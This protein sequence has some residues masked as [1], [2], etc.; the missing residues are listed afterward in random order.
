LINHGAAAFKRPAGQC[1]LDFMKTIPND[2][3]IRVPG[4]LNREGLL[5]C[6]PETLAEVLVHK[7]YDYEKPAEVRDFLV[8][9]LGAGLILTEGE[10]HKFQRKHITP[11]FSFRHIKELIPVFWSRSTAMRDGILA[12]MAE[13]PESDGRKV[14]EI[15]DWATKVTLDIIGVA[16]LGRDFRSLTTTNDPLVENYEEILEPTTE[17]LVYFVFNLLFGIRFVSWLPWKLNQRM[18]A[19]TGALRAFCLNLVHQKKSLMKQEGD[20]SLDI[21]S[22]LIKSNCFGDD[23]LVD[24]LLTF[25][26]AGYFL[27][28]SIHL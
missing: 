6:S 14:V 11:A 5:P 20:A 17:K 7:N 19:T 8:R 10:E 4:F 26:A 24:Q 15:N 22:L 2:G 3:L 12:E 18:D 21:L 25:I 1:F 9:I 23:T 27:P 28:H 16:G 13:N